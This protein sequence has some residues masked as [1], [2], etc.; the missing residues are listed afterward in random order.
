[1]SEVAAFR[2]LDAAWALGIRAF[3][4]AEAY[5]ASAERLRKWSEARANFES[6][7]IVTKVALEGPDLTA[8]SLEETANEAL[9]RFHGTSRL[10]ILSHGPADP[11]RWA[12]IVAAA[13]TYN[14]GVGQSVYTAEE[15]RKALMLPS[16]ERI[17]VPGNVAD[18][19]A[20]SAR[21]DTSAKLDVRSVY[22]QGIL[23]ENPLRAEKRAP[24][25]G[26][27]VREIR[28]LAASLGTDLAPLLIA[29]MLATVR[30][31]DRLVIGVDSVEELD[32]ISAAFDL[33]REV[34]QEF[35]GKLET[36]AGD[37][38][39]E[40]FLDPRAWSPRIVY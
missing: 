21:G 29:S 16:V 39:I 15:V 7:E 9:E 19:R 20:I 38:D 12:S 28:S 40:G 11:D 5:G 3:D 14:A 32:A 6:L 36:L 35:T 27:F 1:M 17:Q 26:R 4:T 24:G 30:E 33:S 25:S 34:V 10:T 31:T 23:L 13:H 37:P 2:I 22:L 8:A 18:M